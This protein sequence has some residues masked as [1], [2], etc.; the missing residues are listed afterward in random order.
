MDKTLSHYQPETHPATNKLLCDL[1]A[2]VHASED[3]LFIADETG[4]ILTVNKAYERIT[5]LNASEL[6][7]K[8]LRRLIGEGYYDAS[9]TLLAI[10]KKETV[11]LNQTIKGN[12]KML[13]TGT[14]FF[15]ETGKLLRI[16]THVRDIDRLDQLQKQLNA[17]RA[18]YT[19]T[20][21]ETDCLSA[22]E[23]L[24]DELISR[25]PIMRD[26]VSLAMQV[27]HVDS[28]IFISGESGT[29]K[30]LVAK[31]IH[32]YGNPANAPFIKINCGAIPS[33]L[34]ESELFGYEGGAFTSAK[35]EGKPGIFELAD[36]GTLFLDEICELPPLLQV[37][38]L[39]AIQEKAV[40]RV[41]GTRI[42]PI[43]TRIIAA[44]NRDIEK[45][46]R[47]KQF[48]EDLYYRLMVI[49]IN[50]PPLRYRKDD[51]PLLAA[52]FI[53]KLN[54]RFYRN[55]VLQP[56]VVDKLMNYDWPGNVRELENV[57]ERMIVTS[58]TPELTLDNLPDTI[59]QKKFVPSK[60]TPFR[61]AIEQTETFMLEE[62][63]KKY[64][65]WALVASA[66]GLDRTTVF[67][68]A[69]KLGLLKKLSLQE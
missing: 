33:Q 45:M 63:Y 36:G 25:N 59:Y 58:N 18:G 64:R 32:R 34:L 13:I 10:E 38:L 60:N 11:V 49:P 23:A 7:G 27:A 42:I 65:S 39:H 29:G 5:G 21:C 24:R 4:V 52:H 41:G 62:N 54:I 51:I 37:K 3:G 55:S 53:K 48:R 28:T 57:I 50:L 20:A 12:R 14:P 43:N 46:V 19:E 61:S 44:T 8:S 9:A 66:L 30:E 40:I 35:K 17:L 22:F 31:T 16:V 56:E 15:D 67:R 6:I 26:I 47:E 1:D 2:I 68:K 69:R